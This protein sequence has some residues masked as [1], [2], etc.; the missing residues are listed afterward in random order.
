M[1]ENGQTGSV[2]TLVMRSWYSTPAFA[3]GRSK[4]GC[5]VRW[6]LFRRGLVKR[7]ANLRRVR[8]ASTEAW[9]N[10]KKDRLI[11]K[12]QTAVGI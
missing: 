9:A 12:W 6:A 2:A 4:R 1:S 10:D 7:S 5:E 3:T 11:K 8:P